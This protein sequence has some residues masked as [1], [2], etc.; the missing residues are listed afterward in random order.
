M[1]WHLHRPDPH[2]Y[3]SPNFL[4]RMNARPEPQAGH[5]PSCRSEWATSTRSEL[6]SPSRFLCGPQNPPARL[7][8][9]GGLAPL[10]IGGH[11]L[12]GFNRLGLGAVR[13]VNQPEVCLTNLS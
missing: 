1:T 11:L 12:I 8:L 10:S 13:G 3:R 9:P 2:W 4:T 6:A 7:L 5:F